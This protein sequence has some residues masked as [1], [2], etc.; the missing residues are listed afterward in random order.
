LVNFEQTP[1]YQQM[2]RMQPACN[3][4]I[5]EAF[6]SPLASIERFAGQPMF[7]LDKEFAIDVRVKLANG[8]VITGQ[9]KSLSYKFH[10]FRTFTV[11]FWQNRFT[12]EPGEFFKIA[13]QF[14]LHGYSDD[15]GVDWEEYYIIDVLRLMLWLKKTSINTLAAKTRPAAG[16]NAAFLPIPYDDL[17]VGAVLKHWRKGEDD[18]F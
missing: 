3:R 5:G 11:E 15:T 4:I 10:K 9:E 18:E 16:S 1:E 13:S 14:Y 12:R 7:V 2:L 6:D 8:T 17:P